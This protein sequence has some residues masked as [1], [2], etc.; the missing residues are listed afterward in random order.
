MSAWGIT[1]VLGSLPVGGHLL[2]SN[3]DELQRAVEP[4]C[5][6]ADVQ[7][8]A[9]LAELERISNKLD[10]IAGQSSQVLP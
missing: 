10:L 7:P 5:R 6:A 2:A 4:R 1:L 9:D 3:A 8:K